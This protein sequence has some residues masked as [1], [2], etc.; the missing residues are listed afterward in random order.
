MV[1]PSRFATPG[2]PSAFRDRSSRNRGVRCYTP[3]R[4]A[5]PQVTIPYRPA[6]PTRA[7]AVGHAKI[8]HARRW[9][10]SGGGCRKVSKAPVAKSGFVALFSHIKPYGTFE[11]ERTVASR[12]SSS[13]DTNG[14]N[15]TRTHG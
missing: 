1:F 13:P 3:K 14:W 12:S 15:T 7:H 2:P 10:M 11:F 4:F 6:L 5:G 8:G 9:R